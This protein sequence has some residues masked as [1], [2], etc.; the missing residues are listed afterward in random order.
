LNTVDNYLYKT[1]ATKRRE[2]ERYDV[3]KRRTTAKIQR[4]THCDVVL[5]YCVEL[6]KMNLF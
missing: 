5:S 3:D 6:V 2:I 1:A 4:Q